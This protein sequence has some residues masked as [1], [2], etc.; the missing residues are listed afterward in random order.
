MLEHPIY[1]A[2]LKFARNPA[3][4]GNISA[5]ATYIEV[6]SND[7]C[8]LNANMVTQISAQQGHVFIGIAGGGT[9][10]FHQ[11]RVPTADA[12]SVVVDLL[13]ELGKPQQHGMNVITFLNG[14]VATRPLQ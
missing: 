11:D 1:S 13:R 10:T 14:Q 2:F 12:E 7:S 9:K 8:F 6:G 5:V 4:S 3:A